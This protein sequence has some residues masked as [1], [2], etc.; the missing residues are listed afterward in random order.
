L[1]E[2]V[3]P[4]PTAVPPVVQ[5]VGAV[6]C[7]PKTVKVIVPVGLAPPARVALIAL[8]AIAVFVASLAG[9]LAVVVVLF[10]ATVEV[11]PV[12]QVLVEALSLVSPL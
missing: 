3:T 6:A 1:P 8:T 9:P 12:P 5:V 10:L 11:I 4:V 2:T 7:G